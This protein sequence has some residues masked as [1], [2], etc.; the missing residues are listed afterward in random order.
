MAVHRTKSGP[1]PVPP[2]ASFSLKQKLEGKKGD[3]YNLNAILNL[4]E[5]NI[6]ARC[7]LDP[8]ADAP[9]I[10]EAS[11][12]KVSRALNFE[13]GKKKEDGLRNGE[14]DRGVA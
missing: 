13:G 9:I 11:T 12:G 4:E 14:R 10:R 2:F 3:S 8:V 1:T 5:E 6:S 7:E